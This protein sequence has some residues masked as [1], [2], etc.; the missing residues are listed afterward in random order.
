M[1]DTFSNQVDYV[2]DLVVRDHAIYFTNQSRVIIASFRWSSI[3]GVSL[4]DPGD[5]ACLQ[6][7]KQRVVIFN[8][9]T[10]IDINCND[11]HIANNIY[12]TLLKKI[13][14]DYGGLVEEEE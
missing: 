10:P 7:L 11:E 12:N 8:C 1:S 9:G 6:D 5:I 2:D 4:H 3:T 13:D 14:V